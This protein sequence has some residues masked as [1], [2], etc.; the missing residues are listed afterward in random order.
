MFMNIIFCTSPF[1]VLVAREIART[2]GEKFIGIYQ[3]MSCDD[4]QRTYAEKMSE[5]CEDVLFIE[6]EDWGSDLRKKL[7]NVK[8]EKFYLASLDN[9]LALGIFNFAPMQLFT[10]DDGSTSLIT[11]N[12][13]TINPNR[14]VSHNGMTLRNVIE[15]SQGHYTVFDKNTL[16]PDS[17]LIKI[18]FN[19]E[20]DG[21][22]RADNGKT[23][24]VFLGQLLGSTIDDKDIKLT[25]KLIN[26]ALTSLGD[27]LY[28]PHPRVPLKIENATIVTTNFCFEEEIYRLLSEYEFVEVYGFYSTSFVLIKDIPGVSVKSF[29]TFLTTNEAKVYSDLG[30]ECIDLP[31]SDTAVDIIMPVYNSEETVEDAIKSVLNQTHTNYRLIIVDDGSTDKMEAVCKKYLEDNRVIYHKVEHEGISKALNTGISLATAKYIARQDSDDEW[32]PW[33][34]DFLLNELDLNPNLDIIGSKVIDDES[35]LPGGIRRNA[36]NNLS[37]EQL[38]LAL[39]YENI[40]N[41]A[42]V[43]FKKEAYEQAGRYD[44]E[45]DGFEDWHLWARMVTKDN[46][47]VLNT[48][49]AHYKLSD[50]YKK[51]MIFR[52]RLARSRGLRLEDVLR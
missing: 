23:I 3:R 15:L 29:R 24:K 45:F 47:L 39:A 1:Q 5:F 30:I 21:F 49:T 4:R 31:S 12:M 16:F 25:E 13:Y 11:P 10:F 46:A 38:W 7:E 51:M 34:L 8:L 17:K 20:P 41:H 22:A 9:R 43:I 48:V 6:N 27:A 40:F 19:V 14:V 52:N 28:Y 35:K 32:M 36:S 2:T 37:G 33:H 18:G 44:S 42:T 26:K 50:A